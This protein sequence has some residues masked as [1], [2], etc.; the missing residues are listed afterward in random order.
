MGR[1]ICIILTFGTENPRAT[2]VGDF[3]KT[4]LYPQKTIS[5]LLPAWIYLPGF[6]HNQPRLRSS[7]STMCKPE[8]KVSFCKCSPFLYLLTPTG[9]TRVFFHSIIPCLYFYSAILQLFLEEPTLKWDS[10]DLNSSPSPHSECLVTWAIHLTILHFHFL[11]LK[12]KS[13]YFAYIFLRK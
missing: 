3:S 7:V 12:E 8:I 2:W 1:N 11:T 6:S 5:L 10:G 9:K 4:V 13:K